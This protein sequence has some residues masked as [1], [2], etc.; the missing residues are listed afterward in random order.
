MPTQA[1]E[2]VPIVSLAERFADGIQVQ[3][4]FR[5]SD[6]PNNAP[7]R[8]MAGARPL[9]GRSRWQVTECEPG[10]RILCTQRVE[11]S[12]DTTLWHLRGRKP[13]CILR[14]RCTYGN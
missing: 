6:I 2:T 12:L 4:H 9:D 3:L 10:G 14:V 11:R 7:V 13:R 1:I 8:P 5:T